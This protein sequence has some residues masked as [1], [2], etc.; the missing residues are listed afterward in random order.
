VVVVGSRSVAKAC[1]LPQQQRM[2][3][4]VGVCVLWVHDKSSSTMAYMKKQQQL[5]MEQA[6]HWVWVQE[7]PLSR[8]HS[9][10]QHPL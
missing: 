4:G 6:C 5:H 2:L 10:Q 1:V 8:T 9:Q 3:V 7:E